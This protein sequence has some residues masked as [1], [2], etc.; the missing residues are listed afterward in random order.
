MAFLRDNK[1]NLSSM[2]LVLFASLIIEI[3]LIVV[4]I[5]LA[6]VECCKEVSDWTGLSYVL[7]AIISIGAFTA[8][9][10]SIQKKYESD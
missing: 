1:G 8:F 6:F 9:A 7:V 10:K 2:R 4:W 5:I 3:V